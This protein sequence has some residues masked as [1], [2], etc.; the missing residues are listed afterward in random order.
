[1]HVYP[2]PVIVSI[3]AIMACNRCYRLRISKQVFRKES[4]GYTGKHDAWD[5]RHL[6]QIDLLLNSASGM[7]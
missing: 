6:A 3:I 5:C 2:A 7:V 1:V 4:N